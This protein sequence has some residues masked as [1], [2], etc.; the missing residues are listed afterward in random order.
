MVNV[1]DRR[2]KMQSM[3][4]DWQVA[5]SVLRLA[6]QLVDGVQEGLARRGF[7]DVR[8]AHGF[9]F[10]RLAAGDATTSDVAEHL[11]V[12]KQ[13]ASQ[14][15]AHLVL[16]GYVERRPDP[17]DARA[18]LL[19]LTARGRACTRAAEAAAAETVSAW[20]HE[21]NP[22][23]FAT[24]SAALRGIAAPGPLRPAW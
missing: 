4:D 21:V 12:T 18:R 5:T 22:R 1:L 20:R 19:V 11:G 15:V 9:A 8:P 13:A 14:L 7:D 2:V 16:G 6:T 24:M 3:T 17:R 23:S 10:A